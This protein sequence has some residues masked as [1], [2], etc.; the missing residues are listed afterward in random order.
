MTPTCDRCGLGKVRS[1]VGW[2]CPDDCPPTDR[3]LWRRV[4]P[5]RRGRTGMGRVLYADPA[6]RPDRVPDAWSLYHWIVGVPVDPRTAGLRTLME[7][8]LRSPRWWARGRLGTAG[9]WARLD[10]RT[11]ALLLYPW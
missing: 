7:T 4:E 5:W 11:S 9:V 1:L 10:T 3:E 6:L 8:G 2:V